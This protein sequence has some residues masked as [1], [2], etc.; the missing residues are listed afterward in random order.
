M[1][2]ALIRRLLPCSLLAATLFSVP[3]C[4]QSPNASAKPATDNT[5]DKH[6]SDKHPPAQPIPVRYLQG[7]VHGFLQ[8]RSDD[9][10]AVASGDSIQTVR[11][12]EVTTRTMFNFKDGSVDDETTVFSQRG[13]FHLITYHHLQKGPF[14]PHPT[15]VLID[16]RSG[17]VTVHSTGKDGKDEVK[18]D[19]LTLPPDL[20]NG[21]VP[22]VIEHIKSG[23]AETTVPM[24]VLA[25]KPRLIKL[26]I[27]P[28][29]EEP[30]DIMGSPRKAIHYEIQVQIGGIEGMVAPFVG[31]A[32]P[33][34][35]L[36]VIG[37]QAPTF[38][39]EV[40][41]IYPEGPMMTIELA[42]PVWPDAPK[43]VS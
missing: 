15:D 35:Q 36:W 3:L 32:P 25:P 33:K 40:G 31:K 18:T 20:A 14:F 7:T 1:K 23:V 13:A 9:G 22:L 34:I 27:S 39:R 10:K 4:A 24:L 11:G 12:S 26:L 17:Q 2:T 30:F 38:L 28:Q 37:G 19:H 16:G 42:S 6:N 41:P 29:G 43:P 21:M 8:M 5:K